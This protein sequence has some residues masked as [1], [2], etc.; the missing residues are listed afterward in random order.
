MKIK[1]SKKMITSLLMFTVSLLV[2][3]LCGCVS[4]PQA[5]PVAAKSAAAAESL[6]TVDCLLP[7]Q[8]RKLGTKATYLTAR[9][10]IKASAAVCEIRGG[11]YAAYDRA[12]YKTALSVWLEQAQAGDPVAQVYVGEIYEKGL[13][14]E[15]DYSIARQWYIKAAEAGNSRAKI[16]LGNIYEQGLGVPV[17]KV[18]ALNWYRKA[19]GFN[20]DIEYLSTLNARV[21]N[22]A[23]QIA[24]GYEQQIAD[25]KIQISTL[26]RSL[27][28][29][30]NTLQQKSSALADANQKLESLRKTVA[31]SSGQGRGYESQ[32]QQLE[33]QQIRV[34]QMREEVEALRQQLTRQMASLAKP[35]I[36]IMSPKMLVTRGDTPQLTLRSD[37]DEPLL[38]GR[39]LAPAGL[40]SAYIDD[41]ILSPNPE[42][43]FQTRLAVEDELRR[44]TI[45]AT[46]RR[47]ETGELKFVVLPRTNRV[48]QEQSRVV[49]RAAKDIN[50][51]RYHALIIA[52]DFYESYPQLETPVKDANAIA[53]VLKQKYGFRT[54][55]V[56][57][58]T[59]AEII[60]SIDKI[61]NQVTEEDNLLI[62]YAGHGEIDPQTQQGFWLPIDAD[63][64]N[65]A[66][67]IANNRI[68]DMINTISAKHILVV[69]DSCYSGSMSTGGIPQ[70]Q[71]Q[72]NDDYIDRWLKVMNKTPSRTVLTSG[73]VE[74]VLDTVDGEHSV[75]AQAFLNELNSNNGVI[76]A[77]RV[78]LN[79]YDEVRARAAEVGFT[80]QPSYAPIKHAG[81]AGGEFILV[82]G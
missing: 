68:T 40:Q 58:A 25:Q 71:S 31:D 79:V 59:R 14:L 28:N 82:G 38:K 27:N 53:K 65:T 5:T 9:R 2:T 63:R 80:Q 37:G 23:E 51:G 22:R 13:G 35:V 1:P 33:D 56:T 67:W 32:A 34:S 69:A 10:P 19:S 61:K 41:R 45:T 78:Y 24:I 64:N 29:T 74:P 11:D 12:N 36:E 8:V 4:A 7:P 20:D 50:F 75:F 48:E 62:Y 60:T 70:L 43:L 49:T 73:G 81:H 55:V 44:V 66:Q 72:L 6:L 26:Q 17:D 15:P 16:N 54:T 21:E 76:D 39:I 52:N 57:N 30:E 3:L 42:G 47:G 77:Y 46:D 18:A